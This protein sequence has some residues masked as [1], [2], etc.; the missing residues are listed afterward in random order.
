MKSKNVYL[1]ASGDL[2]LSANQECWA[3]QFSMEKQLCAAAKKLGY[4]IIRAHKIDKKE[5]H[6]FISS[7]RM[8]MEI[9]KKIPK[10]APLI[11]AESVWQYT[12]HVFAGL[13]S[14]KGRILIAA[15]WSPKW[16]GLVG[17]LNLAGS[18]TKA[19]IKYD[20]LWSENFDDKFFVENFKA[21]LEGKKVKYDTS[22]VHSFKSKS[23][24]ISKKI[25][26]TAKKMAAEIL[27]DKLILG[28]F[29]E[30][31]MGMHNAIIPEELL[32][33]IG[34]FK[35]RLSQSALFY[36]MTQTSNAEAEAAYNWLIKNSMTFHFGKD[37]KKHLTKAQVLEQC[38][39]YI[40]AARF[41][42][43]FGC[44]AIGIQYQQGLKD[45][46]AA[47]DLVEGLLNNS[48][49]PPVKNK[50]GKI[51]RDGRPITNFNEVDECAG[52]DGILTERVHRMLKQPSENT[53]H[54]IRWGGNLEVDGKEEFVWEF[55]ISGG[56]PAEHH[57]GGYAGTHGWRQPPMYFPKGGATCSGVAKAGEIVWSRI[58]IGDGKLKMDIG[59]GR[60]PT[61]DSKIVQERLDAST[62]QWPIM[63]AVLYGVS[64]DQ[65]MSKHK[66]NHIQVAYA[67]N[68]KKAD[69]CMY[70]KAALAEQLGIS[71]NFCG[72]I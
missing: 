47:S 66:A 53:L 40:A 43:E 68:A 2:R 36:K 1:V 60:V 18:L 46:C 6:G 58:Y 45:T 33:P 35:E 42:D 50:D 34:V 63:N 20:M 38:K 62:P 67:T 30:G 54:D 61:L 26:D 59:R 13:T 4:N 28:I 56:A 27:R 29:D 37:P 5:K 51:I 49:R 16:P 57:I 39:M 14:H 48:K 71:V 8:G 7:Q 25:T 70:L 17:A 15:N 12:H 31:C 23:K 3:E 44:D 21:W 69:E 55:L 24:K 72:D 10:D 19:N 64:R 9:F 22:H 32:I 65:L 52:L 41:F 11:V